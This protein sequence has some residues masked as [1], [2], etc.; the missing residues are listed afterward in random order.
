MSGAQH[1]GP[2][3]TAAPSA[4]LTM[5]ALLVL[6]EHVLVGGLPAPQ[7]AAALGLAWCALPQNTALREVDVNTALK[8]CLADECSFLDVDHVEL[9]RWLVDAGWL[10]RDGFGREY[11]RVAADDLTASAAQIAAALACVDPPRWVADIRAAEM[12]RRAARR[13]AWETRQA[14]GH[15]SEQLASAKKGPA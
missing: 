8:R 3:S 9:R 14:A 10:T 15:D 13:Q 2:A 12:A 7:Q 6:K 5:L 4:V 1:A 11:R